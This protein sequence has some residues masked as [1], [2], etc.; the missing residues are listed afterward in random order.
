M[1]TILIA[2]AGLSGL[3]LA[4]GL[5][6]DGYEV[7]LMTLRSAQ[8]IRSGRV[9]SSQ[10]L[11]GPALRRERREGLALWDAQAPR[12]DGIGVTSATGPEVEWT[13]W[14]EEPAQSI[15]QRVTAAAWLEEFEHRGGRVLIHGATVS[16]LDWLAGRYDLTIVATGKGELSE[17]FRPDPGRSAFTRPQR[18]LTLAYVHGMAEDPAG[19]V[20]RRSLVRG[21]G[22]IVS[23]PSYT[24]GGACH[25]ILVE[26]VPDGPM[27]A[28]PARREDA[29][30]GLARVLDLLR[31]HAPWE[32]ERARGAEPADARSV[33]SGGY[34]PLVRDPVGHLPGGAPV[35]AMGDAA[36]INDPITAQGAN[37][38]LACADAY[39]RAILDHGDR[40]F[41][42]RFM[43][44]AFAGYWRYARHAV[45]WTSVMLA[46]PQHVWDLLEAAQSRQ[47]I[48]D[49]FAHGFADPADLI[50]W[51][52]HPE[53]AHAFLSRTGAAAL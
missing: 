33:L 25:A 26:A 28:A 6:S 47:E 29:G 18:R 42:V 53:R 50:D 20:M 17:L 45:A 2:G 11:F 40:P 48:A 8:E 46:A 38:A 5:Q 10:C 43:R 24:M 21:A 22:E 30:A 34:T 9:M 7:T 3:H 1:R 52:L 12:I 32:Y 49:R 31:I 13:G 37:A 39:R 35:L 27:D 4:L 19:A 36:V 16:D 41:D 44:S 23:M 51:F 15:D 14:L